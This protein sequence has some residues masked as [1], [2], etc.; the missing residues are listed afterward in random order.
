MNFNKKLQ[1][2]AKGSRLVDLI[3]PPQDDAAGT[4]VDGR[5]HKDL[6]HLL[7]F[8]VFQHIKSSK[9]AS[10]QCKIDYCIYGS[11]PLS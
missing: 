9:Y 6:Y 11:V 2:L 3:H 8:I 7:H 1:A 10:P 5:F 4:L